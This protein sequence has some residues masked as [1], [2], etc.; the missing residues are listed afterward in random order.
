[1]SKRHKEPI[2][3][4]RFRYGDSI[5]IVKDWKSANEL[6]IK[7]EIACLKIPFDIEN[8]TFAVKFPVTDNLGFTIFKILE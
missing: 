5:Y 7:K 3:F 1:L 4:K 8:R 6:L 2:P